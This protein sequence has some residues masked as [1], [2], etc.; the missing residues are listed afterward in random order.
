MMSLHWLSPA[1]STLALTLLLAGCGTKTAP[2]AWEPADIEDGTTCSLDGMLLADYAGPKA[3][4][5]YAGQPH[6]EFYCDTV[7]MFSVLLASEQ[8][9]A[10]RAVH[11]QDMGQADWEEPR[12]RWIDAKTAFYVRGSRLH[13]SMGPTFASFARREDAEAFR[14]QYGGELLSFD[15]VIPEMVDLRGGALH[16]AHM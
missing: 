8:S 14:G 1:V 6:P 11:V 2:H 13:G 15:D 10:M 3:Q 9:R 16:D 4:I 12:G 5:H 7:E